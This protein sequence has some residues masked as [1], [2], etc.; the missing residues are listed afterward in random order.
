MKAFR[1]IGKKR[2]TNEDPRFVTGRGRYVADIA[3]PGMKHIALVTSPHAS[4]RIKAIRTDKALAMEGVHYVLT[5]EELCANVDPLYVEVDAP[6]VARYP[7][8][9]G[10]VRYA[11]EW[12]VAVV[13][14]SPRPSEEA[15]GEVEGVGWPA[16]RPGTTGVSGG[17]GGNGPGPAGAAALTARTRSPVL[18]W[19]VT[20]N[21][22]SPVATIGAL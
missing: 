19:V 8:A 22:A 13:A 16:V 14:D 18:V 1:Y 15:A 11:G 9:C 2:R 12:V 17:A 20:S 7:L 10:V 6:K 4:A 21:G 3:L 5:G